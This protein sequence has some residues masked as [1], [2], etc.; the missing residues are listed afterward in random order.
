M[1]ECKKVHAL[2]YHEKEIKLDPIFCDSDLDFNIFVTLHDPG[3]S[4][5]DDNN[6][7]NFHERLVRDL[8]WDEDY[9][10]EFICLIEFEYNVSTRLKISR[11]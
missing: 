2:Q 7:K 1:L 9:F 5:H 6:A 10:R 4:R 8:P 3:L 11:K